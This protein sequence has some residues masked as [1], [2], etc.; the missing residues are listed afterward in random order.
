MLRYVG[1]V[2]LGGFIV[3]GCMCVL[4]IGTVKV[5]VF[6]LDRIAP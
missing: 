4:L 1:K 2:C 5:L 6:G 3:L